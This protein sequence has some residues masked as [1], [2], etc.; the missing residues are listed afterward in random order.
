MKYQQFFISLRLKHRHHEG[1]ERKHQEIDHIFMDIPWRKQFNK[2]RK[3]AYASSIDSFLMMTDFSAIKRVVCHLSQRKLINSILKE[4]MPLSTQK[5]L[6]NKIESSIGELSNLATLLY[7]RKESFLETFF[8]QSY[9]PF[10]SA[11]ELLDMPELH[12][13]T[14]RCHDIKEVFE[15]QETENEI[16]KNLMKRGKITMWH[17]LF[18]Q[19]YPQED[20]ED[21]TSMLLKRILFFHWILD[22]TISLRKEITDTE[23]TY[24]SDKEK[25]FLLFNNQLEALQA[26][27]DKLIQ[28]RHYT[29]DNFKWDYN[30]PLYNLLKGKYIKDKL[31]SLYHAFLSD[32]SPITED[33]MLEYAIYKRLQDSSPGD[34]KLNKENAKQLTL[35]E[36]EPKKEQKIKQIIH[37]LP[38][39]VTLKEKTKG[40]YK[41]EGHI[42][43]SVIVLAGEHAKPTNILRYFQ[44][45]YN[46]TPKALSNIS[47]YIKGIKEGKNAKDKTKTNNV[48]KKHMKLYHTIQNFYQE[49]SPKVVSY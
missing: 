4:E 13:L 41:I 49:N 30:L 15:T 14:Q 32:G 24:K 6:I 37:D 34:S 36:N 38:R 10:H 28:D 27:A 22:Q 29:T 26:E 7:N 43:A 33:Q 20:N 47:I 42:I 40:E 11:Q 46:N 17:T 39:I 1:D 9:E 18:E 16:I 19:L 35:V 25:C 3:M 48:Y 5:M 23:A 31:P 21:F 45:I 8:P 12:E 2:E 44:T